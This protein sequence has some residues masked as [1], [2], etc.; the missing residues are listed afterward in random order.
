MGLNGGSVATDSSKFCLV[1][2]CPQLAV[3]YTICSTHVEH[4]TLYNVHLYGAVATPKNYKNT[5]VNNIFY[6]TCICHQRCVLNV[7][8]VR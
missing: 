1:V 2:A 5:I 7:V 6:H 3:T 4:C 8:V